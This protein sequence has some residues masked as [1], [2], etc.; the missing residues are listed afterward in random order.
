M[1]LD[2]SGPR[3]IKSSTLSCALKTW[4][5]YLV[6]REFVL[7]SDCDALQHLNSQ[8]RI[9]KDMH[10]RWIQFLQKFLFR[11]RHTARVQNKVADALNRHADLFITLNNKIVGFEL[12]KDL[13]ETDE[14]FWEI[15]KKCIT[16]QPC[17]DFHVQEG[18]LMRGNQLCIPRTSLRENVIQDLHRGGLVDHFD[19]DKTIATVGER[20]CWPHMRRGM[21]KFAQRCYVCQTSKGQSQNTRL[22]TPLPV[23]N[24]IWDDPSMDFVLG[25]PRTQK[26]VNLVFVVVDRFSKM[27][28]FIPCKKTSDASG[29]PRLFF[30]EVVRLHGVPKT[31]TLD[32]DN[33]FLGHFW[34]T[35]RKMFNSSLN[36][37]Y[38]AHLQTDG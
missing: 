10:V 14:D 13:Y 38:T 29:I 18:Y 2:R 12:L 27:A 19:K 4:E 33:K 21:T 8:T 17:D 26:G 9:N 23:P 31:I 1:M 30:R 35:L 7:Y 5:H 3:M 28:H 25:F 34:K 16:N 24:D 37:S 15:W 11:I 6:G 20:H 36:F 22:Y 32:W